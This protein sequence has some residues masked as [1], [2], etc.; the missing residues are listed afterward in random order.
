MK[1]LATPTVILVVEDEAMLRYAI[2]HELRSAGCEVVECGTAEEA[3]ALSRDGRRIDVVFTDIQLAGPLSGWDVA[4]Q[5]RSVD[6]DVTVIYT[7][8]NSADRTRR[9]AHSLFFD[10]PYEPAAVVHACRESGAT[11]AAHSEE[12][13]MQRYF[14]HI[15]NANARLDDPDGGEFADL[16]RAKVEALES[17]RELISQCVLQGRPLGLHRVFEIVDGNGQVLATVP[18]SGAIVPDQK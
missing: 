2:A 5:L 4:E 15:R 11:T 6:A 13:E 7:S 17:A 9:V 16:A 8:G 12:G 14:M 3:I 10:K 18:F 1:L